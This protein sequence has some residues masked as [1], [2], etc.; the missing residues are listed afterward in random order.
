MLREAPDAEIEHGAAWSVR[1]RVVGE[2][3]ESAV[4]LECRSTH[5]YGWIPSWRIRVRL[6][7]RTAIVAESLP[8]ST[9][10]M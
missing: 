4:R 8:C 5:I 10:K 2:G 1:E 6:S 9:R 3:A 7:S